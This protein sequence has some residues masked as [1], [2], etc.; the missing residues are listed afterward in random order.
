MDQ[1]E[2]IPFADNLS[3]E[4]RNRWVIDPNGIRG[5]PANVEYLTVWDKGIDAFI[6]IGINTDFKPGTIDLTAKF[7]VLAYA[8]NI[9]S[10]VCLLKVCRFKINRWK[11]GDS[12]ISG[13]TW[14]SLIF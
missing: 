11:C 1:H 14:I 9:L 13:Y 10:E 5:F 7:A 2:L 12:R 6:L 3:M 4:V 8:R